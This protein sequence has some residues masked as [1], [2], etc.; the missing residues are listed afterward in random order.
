VIWQRVPRLISGL[1]AAALT[2]AL[3]GCGEDVP[4]LR[5]IPGDGVI[6][7]F[8]DSLTHGTG[9]AP[10]ED[11]PQVLAARISRT[12]VNAGIP[13]EITADGLQR[14]P[15]VLEEVQPALVVL[16]H[17]GN[18]ILRRLPFSEAASNLREMIRLS[19]EAGAEVL[20][21][22]VPRFGLFLDAAPFYQ[23]VATE[24]QVPIDIEALSQILADNELK[25][26]TVH[27]NAAG[28][29]KLA[30]AVESLLRERGA[31]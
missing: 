23:Q 17:G 26:D 22:G 18:D 21:L 28:Y 4:Q 5:P 8:G 13:G 16:C 3:M 20:M 14:L 12:V 6:L 9:A 10:G 11:Y 2:A 24:M 15:E 30:T 19:R 25:S 27:P 29:V 31:L 7:A 1:A